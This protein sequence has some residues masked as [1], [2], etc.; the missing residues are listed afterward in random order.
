MPFR[1]KPKETL[2]DGLK[3]I[4]REQVDRAIAEIDDESLPRDEA[5]QQVRKRCKKIRGAVRLVRPVF[6]TLRPEAAQILEDWAHCR[7][8]LTRIPVL[9]TP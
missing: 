9:G 7:R 1:L 5:I 8:R 2:E 6:G 3:R 4:A